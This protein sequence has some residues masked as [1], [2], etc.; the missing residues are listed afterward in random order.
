VTA[1]VVHWQSGTHRGTMLIHLRALASLHL[2][3]IAILASTPE[4]DPAKPSVK[5]VTEQSELVTD[6]PDFTESAEVA[7]RAMFQVETGF[8]IDRS[9]LEGERSRSLTGPFP[10]LRLGVSKR[11]ELRFAGD[12]YSWARLN[13]TGT[14]D[15][16]RGRS[17]FSVGGKVK[18]FDQTT[19]RPDF[20]VI[21]AVSVPKGHPQ[22]RGGGYDPEVKLCFAKDAPLGFVTS[23]N[24][25]L[26]SVSD[27]QGRFLGRAFSLSAGHAVW[28]DLSM[29]S[30]LYNVT[31]DRSMG[32]S[33]VF[34]GGLTHPIGR[35]VQV[36]VL[37]GHSVAGRQVGWFV[38]VGFSMRQSLLPASRH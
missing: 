24:I 36:D 29:Y 32:T 21:A 17:D 12:G 35:N 25:N 6:R 22:F 34:N 14:E 16:V 30:E 9:V 13:S 4:K 31:I 11:V 20:A 33:T 28:R 7:G 10:L 3:S 8:A 27:E 1:P 18:F 37:A 15:H 2:I 26:A 19:A 5:P 38:G 23:W